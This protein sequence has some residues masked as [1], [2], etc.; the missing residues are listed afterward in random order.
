MKK[1]N[2]H[3]TDRGLL[4]KKKMRAVSSNKQKQDVNVRIIAEINRDLKAMLQK[5][6]FRVDMF[7]HLNSEKYKRVVGGRARMA[8]IFA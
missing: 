4:Q 5:R 1:E 7:Y 2:Y 8:C 3:I 6:D